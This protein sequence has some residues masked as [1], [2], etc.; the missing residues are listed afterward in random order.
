[1][2]FSFQV[3]AKNQADLVAAVAAKMEEI[4]AQQPSHSVDKEEVPA[5]TEVYAGMVTILEGHEIHANIS[6][7]VSF[8]RQD[9][10]TVINYTGSAISVGI[11][12]L[13]EEIT[14]MPA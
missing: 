13:P 5:V 11:Y 7:S 8:F 1:M 12:C 6:G 14:G 9:D 4:V 2:S 3:K 10:G